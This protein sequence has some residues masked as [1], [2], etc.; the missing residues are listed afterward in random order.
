[1]GKNPDDV[2][3]DAAI[4]RQS[5]QHCTKYL[6]RS[7]QLWSA[8]QLQSAFFPLGHDGARMRLKSKLLMAESGQPLKIVVLGGSMTYGAQS[9]CKWSSVLA[10]MLKSSFQSTVQLVNLAKRGSASATILTE[11][12]TI[13]KQDADIII[14]DYTVNDGF[15]P[16]YVG[17]SNSWFNHTSTL[18]SLML[19]MRSKPAVV[20][21]ETFTSRFT[22]DDQLVDSP[23][24]Q[25]LVNLDVPTI[26]YRSAL[27][28]PKEDE[29]TT[30]YQN[31][32]IADGPHPAHPPCA[33]H[34]KVA[35]LVYTFFENLLEEVRCCWQVSGRDHPPAALQEPFPEARCLHAPL[36][37][38]FSSYLWE[39]QY[40][41]NET[42]MMEYRERFP[43]INH[44]GWKLYADVEGKPGWVANATKQG[45]IQFKVKTAK[46]AGSVIL[47]Y[48]TT[49]EGIGS[50]ECRLD[51]GEP[52]T[53]NGKVTAKASLGKIAVFNAVG[54]NEE[55]TLTCRTNMEKFKILNVRS[56]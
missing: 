9:D 37:R 50:A 56:C 12:D 19:R 54:R 8:N 31:G 52:Q 48:L 10:P 46:E 43:A 49:Y 38:L 29:M 33:V 24:W 23:H 26:S 55:R 7:T 25:A 15:M 45:E 2:D 1:M 16:N 40:Y 39:D 42:T 47:E 30:S 3:N 41:V 28:M 34:E 13:E 51:D 21:L 14:V 20:Y 44:S 32:W 6:R 22:C 5:C 4:K 36:T 11:T 35:D 53:L 17:T 18:V 27:C